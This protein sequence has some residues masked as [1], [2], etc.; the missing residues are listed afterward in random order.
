MAQWFLFVPWNNTPMNICQIDFCSVFVL[1]ISPFEIISNDKGKKN[2]FRFFIALGRMVLV[3]SYFIFKKNENTIFLWGS[4]IF[5]I[6][7]QFLLSFQLCSPHP[8]S[9]HLHLYSFHCIAM[10]SCHMLFVISKRKKKTEKFLKNRHRTKEK[11][12]ISVCVCVRFIFL[13]LWHVLH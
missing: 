10:W 5:C 11:E 7:L 1:D 4:F 6:S 13:K 2:I 12:R 3:V 9:G 8:L